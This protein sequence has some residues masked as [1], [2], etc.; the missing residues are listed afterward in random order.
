[1]N[2]TR[3]HS[4]NPQPETLS[5]KKSSGK[6]SSTRPFTSEDMLCARTS[7]MKKFLRVPQNLVR[8]NLHFCPKLSPPVNSTR[9][10][11]KITK[12]PVPYGGQPYWWRPWWRPSWW[13]PPWWR[14]NGGKAA[15]KVKPKNDPVDQDH[16]SRGLAF[17]L[18]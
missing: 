14:Q 2:N 12:S 5:T 7:G 13:R 8:T 15:A 6:N 1:M 18:A 9:A 10:F 11:R 3:V 17:L 16:S 4:S